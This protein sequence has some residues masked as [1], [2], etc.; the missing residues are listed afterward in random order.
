MEKNREE[1]IVKFI[2]NFIEENGKVCWESSYENGKMC[3]SEDKFRAYAKKCELRIKDLMSE[4]HILY[5]GFSKE[6]Q[7]SYP[8]QH[9]RGN[10]MR[11]SR[12]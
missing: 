11:L 8:N 9:R 6:N 1:G 2:D 7:R 5:F 10:G 3:I 4:N 12:M